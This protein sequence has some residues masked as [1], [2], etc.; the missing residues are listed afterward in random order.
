MLQLDSCR[1]TVS[2]R[3]LYDGNLTGLFFTYIRLGLSKKRFSYTLRG[4]LLMCFTAWWDRFTQ[5]TNNLIHFH[6][7]FQSEFSL[8][9]LHNKVF[10]KYE[11][12]LH[13]SHKSFHF[14]VQFLS[15][16]QRFWWDSFSFFLLESLTQ[17]ISNACAHL[18]WSFFGVF[19]PTL[20]VTSDNS[21]CLMILLRLKLTNCCM[22]QPSGHN[23]PF[24][25]TELE[26]NMSF[27]FSLSLSLSL[28][29]SMLS[30]STRLNITTRERKNCESHKTHVDVVCWLFQPSN[31]HSLTLLLQCS[32]LSVLSTNII[33]PACT[34]FIHHFNKT[35]CRDRDCTYDE[36][37]LSCILLFVS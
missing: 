19:S 6:E 31:P 13:S 1:S 24:P 25:H 9:P 35:I 8:F 27:N 26:W 2:S 16:S 34:L 12:F 18:R 14:W 4:L 37:Y 32:P 7:T 33:L 30:C 22:Q 36:F 11:N 21:V 29:L 3:S 5:I 23:H 10:F 20:V 17:Q 28:S 15:G